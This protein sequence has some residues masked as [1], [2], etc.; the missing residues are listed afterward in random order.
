MIANI[1]DV[2]I[3][4]LDVDYISKDMML[5]LLESLFYDEIAFDALNL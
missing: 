2:D 4:V 1:T 3:I 5:M